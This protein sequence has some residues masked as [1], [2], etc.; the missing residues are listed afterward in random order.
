MYVP[1]R[2]RVYG[3]NNVPA[4]G[5][6]LLLANHQSYLDPIFCQIP[7]RRRMAYV[8][9]DTLFKNRVFRPF[10]HSWG[11]IPVRRGQGDIRA[12]RAVLD[13]LKSGRAVCLFPEGTRSPDGR[14]GPARPGFGLLAR[15]GK[16]R[17]LP[18]V[19][20]G[21]YECWPRHRRLPRFGKVAVCYGPCFDPE[22]V[23]ELDDRAFARLLTET[24]RKMQRRLRLELG[25]PVYEYPPDGTGDIAGVLASGST[26]GDQEARTG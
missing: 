5:P 13:V 26:D 17:V 10:L 19:V 14:I 8:A 18:V 7:L 23:R 2:L 21:A 16:A 24:L 22:Q 12:M 1:F 6:L 25:R 15:R 11:I 3:R 9:R 4:D 20:D